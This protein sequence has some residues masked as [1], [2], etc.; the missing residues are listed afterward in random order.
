MRGVVC[1]FGE[2]A[3]VFTNSGNKVCLNIE[4]IGE[5]VGG[6]CHIVG[7]SSWKGSNAEKFVNDCV[8]EREQHSTLLS[9]EDAG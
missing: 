7:C 4:Q 3:P 5:I 9:S 8:S 6:V 2:C 1:A